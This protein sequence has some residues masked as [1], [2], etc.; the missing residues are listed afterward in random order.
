MLSGEIVLTEGEISIC[1]DMPCP[2]N[3]V[4]LSL[5]NRIY[6]DVPMTPIITRLNLTTVSH[7]KIH[8]IQCHT[9]VAILII[10]KLY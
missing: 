4:L 2:A 1:V 3:V 5:R 10:I 6:I 8:K 9:K 7:A